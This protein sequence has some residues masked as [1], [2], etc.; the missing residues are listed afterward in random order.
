ASHGSVSAAPWVV[1]PTPGR[2]WAIVVADMLRAEARLRRGRPP[3]RGPR[4][5]APW[6]PECCGCGSGLWYSSP[7]DG[8]ALRLAPPRDYRPLAPMV[9]DARAEAGGCH[10]PAPGRASARRVRPRDRRRGCSSPLATARV[11][12]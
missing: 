11:G 10:L 5:A 1:G 6:N 9:E 4:H 12:G 2:L 3:R 8:A 7:Y